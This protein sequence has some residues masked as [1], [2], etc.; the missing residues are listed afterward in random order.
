[1]VTLFSEKMEVNFCRSLNLKT[2]FFGP[3]QTHPTLCH[4][5]S[6]HYLMLL[7]ENGVLTWCKFK[8]CL[9]EH[10]ISVWNV[11]VSRGMT[12][13]FEGPKYC[14]DYKYCWLLLRIYGVRP[15]NRV[16]AFNTFCEIKFKTCWILFLVVY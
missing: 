2:N 14:Y 3:A 1:M 6:I 5:P 9:K 11:V 10:C 16:F 8:H 4:P 13:L 15:Y 7:G 12:C